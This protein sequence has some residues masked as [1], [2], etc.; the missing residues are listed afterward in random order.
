MDEQ[1][2]PHIDTPT[3]SVATSLSEPQPLVSVITPTYNR[4]DFLERTIDS[5]LAQCYANI[6]Y[7][8]LDDGS[9]D[10][11]LELLDMYK[12][13]IRISSHPNM[14]EQK[15][16]NEGFAMAAGKYVTVVNSDDPMK[17][18]AITDAIAFLE[19]RDDLLVAYPDWEMIDENDQLVEHVRVKEYDYE[20]MLGLHD[21]LVGP[22][23][24]IRRE[25]IESA[26]GRSPDYR[27][28][29]DFEFW[30]R[31]GLL[32]PMSR[33][34]KTLATWRTHAD[35]ATFKEQ[36]SEKSR[37]HITLMKTF[38]QREDLPPNIRALKRKAMSWAHYV[39]AIHAGGNRMLRLGH[40]IMFL[41][42]RP[43]SLID[44]WRKTGSEKPDQRRFKTVWSKLFG[45]QH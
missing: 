26:G 24:I 32:G 21:C 1:H 8:V 20:Q 37:E 25:A 28:V 2:E 14:G 39:A 7:I 10:S 34:P 36:G 4:A 16:V 29:A 18:G 22:G 43:T 45:N 12:D 6:E 19:A 35:A 15:T 17:P 44:W 41:L 13:R 42:T 11:T 5:V 30:L 9:T 40:V 3:I 38:F 33:I 27:F 31:L 23:A